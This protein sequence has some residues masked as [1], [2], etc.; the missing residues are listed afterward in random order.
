MH[1]IMENQYV[2]LNEGRDMWEIDFDA[3]TARYIGQRTTLDDLKLNQREQLYEE[4]TDSIENWLEEHG[5]AV[6]AGANENEDTIRKFK[7]L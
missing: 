6:V 3:R 1:F 4:Y 7:K 2:G 5:Y